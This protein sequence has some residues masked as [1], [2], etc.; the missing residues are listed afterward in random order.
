[1]KLCSSAHP[2]LR[3]E[4]FA[5]VFVNQT[6]TLNKTK[7]GQNPM[8]KSVF[9]TIVFSKTVFNKTVCTKIVALLLMAFCL[10]ALTPSSAHAQ[11]ASRMDVGIDY[12]YVWSNAPP[13]GCGCFSLN[14]GNVWAAF[15][16]KRSLGIVGEL[17]SQHASNVPGA[18]ADLTLTSYLAGPRYRWTGAR[19]FTPFAQVLVGGVH[20]SGVLAPGSSGL[21]G[22]ANAF[23]M[24]AGSGLDISITRH[25]A[26]RALE[27]DYFLTR[28]NNGV[29]DHQNNLRLAAGIVIRFGGSD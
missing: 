13:G 6:E 10:S 14:G 2:V 7:T 17:A 19:H 1:M 8:R 12:N 28:F 21:G 16:F 15:N 9:T 4:L 29:N 20:A 23:G 11:S 24:I 27:A 3:T 26:V 22:S 25:M 5:Q 18:D